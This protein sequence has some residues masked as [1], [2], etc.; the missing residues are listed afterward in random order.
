MLNFS[1]FGAP[2][3]GKGTQSYRLSEKYGLKHIS[4]GD[5]FRKEI[6]RNSHIGQYVKDFVDQGQ[7]IP[8]ATVLKEVYRTALCHR[9][10]RGYIFDGFPRTLVQAELMDR[11]LKKKNLDLKLVVYIVVEEDTLRERLYSRAQDSARTD[12]K[13]EV[14]IE[15]LEIYRKMTLPVIEYYKKKGNLIEINGMFP[16]EDVFINI[17]SKIDGFLD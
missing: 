2:G 15:R 4:T 12:D 5:L 6:A 13:K 1:I 16:V 7:L 9:H 8:D 14:I 11:L 3:S 17:C 10:A